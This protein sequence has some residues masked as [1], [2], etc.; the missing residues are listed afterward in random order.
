MRYISRTKPDRSGLDRRSFLRFAGSSGALVLFGGSRRLWAID[1][2]VDPASVSRMEFQV[3]YRTQIMNLPSDAE[4]VRL[5]MPLPSSD[6]AQEVHDLSLTSEVPWEIRTEPVYGSK[7]AY[8]Q[9]GPRPF[10]LEASYRVVRSRAGVERIT[11]SQADAEKYLRFTSRVRVT[12]EV[13][14]FAARVL[15]TSTAPSET[16]RK[17]FDGIRDLLVYDKQIPGCGTGDTAWLMHHRR[18]KCDDYHALF[19]AVMMSRG[20]P[21]RW[22]QGFPLPLPGGEDMASGS[23]AGDCTGAHC[24][25]SFYDPAEG[26][27][28]VDASEAD[29]PGPNREFFFGQVSANRFKVSEGRAVEL[30]P[31]QGGDPMPNFA[32]AYAE[33]DGIPLIYAA[34]YENVIEYEITRVER[35]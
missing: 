10:T 32:Y 12:P 8:V 23:L 5:W 29:K 16:A 4:Q 20:I 2:T 24:W 18:G 3:S 1:A 25:V 15:G 13:E 28:P 19:M 35:G 33:A 7:L 34:N 6:H 31:R 30:D 11:L 21:V 22:E 17:L 9:T 27:V 14:E 26:F